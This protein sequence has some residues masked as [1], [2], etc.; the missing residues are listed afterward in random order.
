MAHLAELLEASTNKTTLISI[1]LVIWSVV[2]GIIIAQFIMFYN[3]RIIGS[4]F[5]AL[6]REEAFDEESAKSIFEIGQTA[7][8]AVIAKLKRSRSF[9]TLVTSL[10][11]DEIPNEN[12]KFYITEEQRTRIRDQWGERSESVGVLIGGIVGMIVFGFLVTIVAI[13]GLA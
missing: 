3:R 10:D 13:L 4:F 5:R 11:G 12:T 9:R 8:D 2:L 6:I 1:T 7:N